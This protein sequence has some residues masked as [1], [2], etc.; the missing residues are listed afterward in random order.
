MENETFIKKYLQAE[1]SVEERKQFLLRLKSDADFAEEVKIHSV[2]FKHRHIE[3]ADYLKQS[4]D[5]K[6]ITKE[7]QNLVL[8]RIL[9]NVAAIF[10]L[11]SISY[12]SYNAIAKKSELSDLIDLAYNDPYISP[13]ILQSEEQQEDHWSKAIEHYSA[14]KYEDAA[15]EILKIEALSNEQQFY[16]GLSLMYQNP[17]KFDESISILTSILDHPEN[18]HQDATMWYLSI[19]YLKTKQKELAKPLLEKIAVSKYSY[20]QD[21]IEILHHYEGL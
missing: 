18:L 4:T 20:Q 13:G 3:F 1:L 21:A 2:L 17:P 19:T 6:I 9:R 11:A 10:I 8:H 15:H 7:S 16:L 5:E 12:F 14:E